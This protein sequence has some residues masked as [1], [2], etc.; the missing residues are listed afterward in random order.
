MGLYVSVGS[1]GYELTTDNTPQSG[2]TYYEKVEQYV[3]GVIYVYDG[4]Q[5]EWVAQGSG[6]TM[7]PI[8]NLEIDALFD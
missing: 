6:D 2:T 4:T 3:T 8:T 7:V 5:S 1:G